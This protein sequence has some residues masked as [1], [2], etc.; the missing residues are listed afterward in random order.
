MK[1]GKTPSEVISTDPFGV[2]KK[3]DLH[4]PGIFKILPWH[5]QVTHA[6]CMH[7][8]DR[9]RRQLLVCCKAALRT[10]SG[11]KKGQTGAVQGTWFLAPRDHMSGVPLSM[12]WGVVFLDAL[13]DLSCLHSM[14]CRVK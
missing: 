7:S 2:L 4:L 6:R 10:L 13:Q 1:R 11:K 5:R 14:R 8:T 3:A 12:V 9:I